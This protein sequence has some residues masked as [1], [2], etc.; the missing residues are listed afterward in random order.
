VLID[1]SNLISS[2]ARAGL[3][4]PAL[5]PL[6]CQLSGSDQLVFAR[7]YASPPP[8]EPWKSR[9]QAMQR[10]NRH[11]PGLE[12][13]QG[14]RSANG[15]EKVIDVAMGVDLISGVD[16]GAFE[17]VV[18]VGGDGDHLYPVKLAHAKLGNA[19]RVHLAP[20]QRL[21]ALGRARIPFTTWT[22]GDCVSAGIA[23]LGAYAPVPSAFTASATAPW[24]TPI[25]TGA[26]GE[27]IRPPAP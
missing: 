8:K 20:G 15:Q 21:D 22:V 25:L 10:A 6:L 23:D 12:F 7:F 13:F 19:L 18:V 24:A 17:R 2:L 27:P 11:V 9:F 5:T 16:S 4:Y 3:G 1:G 14:Y 26:F